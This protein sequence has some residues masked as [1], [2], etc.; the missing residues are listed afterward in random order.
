M[1][2]AGTA[3]NATVVAV[4]GVVLAWLAKG[5]FDGV[6]H[7]IDRLEERLDG[8]IDQLGNRLDGRLDGLDG[9]I[10]R[11]EQRM[12]QRFD[13]LEASVDALRSDITQIAL[14]VGVRQRA[15]NG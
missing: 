13:R 9:R 3:I 11:L 4:V 15:E 7:R 8:R 2:L 5:R 14:A 12:D 6:E 1:E 10:D